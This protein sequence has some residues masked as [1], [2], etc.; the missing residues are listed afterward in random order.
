MKEY[1]FLESVSKDDNSPT[2]SFIG[3]GETGGKAHSLITAE[4]IV[5]EIKQQGK[6]SDVTV[7]IPKFTVLKTDIFDSFMEMNGLY[8]IA[9]SDSEDSRIAYEFQKADLPFETLKDLRELISGSVKPLAVRSSSLLEDAKYEP[10]A[11]IYSTKMLPNNQ[12]DIDT[13]CRKLYEA[14]KLIYA[15]VFFKAPK[16][17]FKATKHN[18]RDEKMAVLIQEVIGRKHGERFYPDISGVARSYNFYPMGRSKPEDGVVD[19]AVGLG[20]AIVD[21]GLCWT[22]SPEDPSQSP[23]FGSVNEILKNTQ[24]EF[25]HIILSE[26]E[27]YDPINETEFMRLSNITAA[28]ED[29][30][31]GM[32]A[33]TVTDSGRITPG[34][35]SDGPRIVNFAPLLNLELL[36][37]NEVIKDFLK[38]CENKFNTP[39]EIEFAM[40]VSGEGYNA[41]GRFGL[42]QVRPMVVSDEKVEITETDMADTDNIVS[43]EYALGNGISEEIT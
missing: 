7:D 27:E 32:S 29:S 39:V 18:I 40:T 19:L 5:N 17:Y 30:A 28:D 38:V 24:T 22:Y 41:E 10:F 42:L 4:E 16:N 26:P 8:E 9:L 35:G 14:V 25:W 3:S 15:S 6:Y 1:D 23:P 21:G 2:S 43:T 13:R 37:L 33:S 12:L 11:G 31:L 20:K 36:P 34:T